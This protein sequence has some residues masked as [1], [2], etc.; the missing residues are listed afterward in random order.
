MLA[1]IKKD[2]SIDTTKHYSHKAK[3]NTQRIRSSYLALNVTLCS[4]AKVTAHA[5]SAM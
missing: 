5:I 2:K 1:T 4:I 3:T